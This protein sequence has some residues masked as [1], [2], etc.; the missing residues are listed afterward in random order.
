MRMILSPSI[1]QIEDIV[2]ESPEILDGALAAIKEGGADSVH[3]DVMD[4]D[5]VQSNRF[6]TA[7]K[8]RNMISS[9]KKAGLTLDTHLMVRDVSRYA[10]WYRGAEI[11]TFHPEYS[12]Y[13]NTLH[14]ISEIR[15]A[16]SLVG[17]A[18]NPSDSIRMNKQYLGIADLLLF[19]TVQA[20]AGGQSFE[21]Y[22]PMVLDIISKCPTYTAQ[23]Q[24]DGGIKPDI[25][26]LRHCIDAGANNF[27][28]GSGITQRCHDFL[29]EGK[30]L[31]GLAALKDDTS[32]ARKML[33][34][35]FVR[36]EA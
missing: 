24:I 10:A 23:V 21:K 16:G 19:M 9:C 22:G 8:A 12:G 20:G 34:V 33:A 3:V 27:V 5:A 32:Y 28:I 36:K 4:H 14:M 35:A 1:L 15:N 17:I 25:S 2:S 13:K 6:E 29:R 31:A 26:L 11:I 30:T 7:A 18:M